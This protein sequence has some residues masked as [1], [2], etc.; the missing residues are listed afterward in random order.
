M[1]EPILPGDATL[2]STAEA[3]DAAD[4]LAHFRD[5]FYID[6]EDTCYLDGNSLGRLPFNTVSAVGEF[7][8]EEW[9]AEAVNGWSHW[10]D[11]AGE[12]GD[13]VAAA[14]LGTGPGQTLVC[15]T[16]S[17]NLY[18]LVGA[19]IR[20]NAG[21]TTIIVDSAN[22][23]TDRYIVQGLAEAH[24][25]NLI[26]LDND[27]SGGPGSVPI[28]TRDELITPE[29]LEPFL[30]DDVA[31]ITLQAIHYRSG[32]RPDMKAINDL[33]RSRGLWLC[34]I[35]RTRLGRSNSTLTRTASTLLWVVRI[36]TETAG[37]ARPRGF[38]S[39]SRCSPLCARRFRAG[40]HRRTSSPWDRCSNR[41]R[42]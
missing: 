7:M 12:V 1:S 29:A 32:A 13:I 23:P 3:L 38:L 6:D 4:V 35:A 26:T 19:A 31:V 14:S 42:R 15:D 34:G 25:M 33:A 17:V 30:T 24:G 40:S 5:R 28:E 36:N 11:E 21:R 16:T 18:Q 37:P 10:I 41:P 2:R 9:G 39:V 20:A 27:G 8:N 22:F